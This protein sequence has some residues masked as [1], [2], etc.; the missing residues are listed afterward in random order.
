MGQFLFSQGNNFP[1]ITLGA[2]NYDS[3]DCQPLLVWDGNL[4]LIYPCRNKNENKKFDIS[5]YKSELNRLSEI[6]TLE[7]IEK[8]RNCCFKFGCTDSSKGH[9]IRV[10]DDGITNYFYLDNKDSTDKMCGY[11]EIDELRLLFEKICINYR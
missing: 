4:N 2:Y 10:E 7:F 8:I 6:V 11:Q 1:E 3:K 5:E 9:F